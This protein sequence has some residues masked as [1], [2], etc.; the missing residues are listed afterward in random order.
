LT[1][2]LSDTGMTQISGPTR[3]L[4]PMTRIGGKR[5]RGLPST[6]SPVNTPTY[7]AASKG[8]L[9]GLG[10]SSAAQP[11]SP[12]T[13]AV[14]TATHIT[15]I[16]GL[17]ERLM[18]PNVTKLTGGRRRSTRARSPVPA[19]P[20][21]RMVR[22]RI[23]HQGMCSMSSGILTQ[24]CMRSSYTEIAGGGNPGSANAP[25]G[26]ATCSSWPWRAQ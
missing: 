22:R 17:N 16:S 11:A 7:G 14:A 20:V 4:E 1:A 13:R 2:R 9:L 8:E 26:I 15:S 5:Y 21:E 19:R 23:A 12:K 6:N 3:F 10:P 18:A 24:E 25:T